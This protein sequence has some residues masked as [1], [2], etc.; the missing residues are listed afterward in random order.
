MKLAGILALLGV[1]SL[2]RIA[3][4]IAKTAHRQ[5]VLLNIDLA[6]RSAIGSLAW[7][8]RANVCRNSASATALSFPDPSCES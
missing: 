1:Y 5:C 4:M 8:N 7:M 2:G 3:Q 6:D